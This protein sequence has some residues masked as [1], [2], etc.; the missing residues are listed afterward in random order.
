MGS[1]RRALLL[2][3]LSLTTACARDRSHGMRLSS[4]AFAAGAAIPK[5]NGCGG[6]NLSPPLAWSGAPAKAR[7]FALVV[8]DPD[9]RNFTH[10][11]LFNV[12]SDVSALP[13]GLRP[14]LLPP[15]AAEGGNDFGGIGWG[16]P[17][18]PIGEHR[19]SFR[20]YALDVPVLAL[21][22]PTKQQ[23]VAAMEGHTLAE[24]QLVGTYRREAP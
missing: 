18:P 24:A 17:C 11:V 2:L 15:G 23:L 14:D 10:W 8:D 7:S 21:V 3:S 22:S 6:E 9:A 12:A 13:E 4:P 5:R 19:Y 16:G 20:L 1:R